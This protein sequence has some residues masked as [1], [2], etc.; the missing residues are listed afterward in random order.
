MIYLIKYA[1]NYFFY[2]FIEV[3]VIYGSKINYYKLVLKNVFFRLFNVSLDIKLNKNFIIQNTFG[4]FSFDKTLGSVLFVTH[5]DI[6]P[7][8]KVEK[9][10]SVAID[11]GANLGF[12]STAMLYQNNFL[13][14][15]YSVEASLDTFNKMK[16]NIALNKLEKKIIPLNIGIGEK[17]SEMDF[18]HNIKNSGLSSFYKDESIEKDSY[19]KIK[20]KIN[21]LAELIKIQKINIKDIGLIKID[22]EGG[23]WNIL[24]NI[25]NFLKKLCSK[26]KVIVELYDKQKNKEDVLSLFKDS[27]FSCDKITDADY[28]FIKK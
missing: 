28:C 15:I 21:S 16:E 13:D 10:F 3:K 20:V 8:L 23:E 4:K 22:V 25:S 19:K 11:I 7:H 17:K 24:K 26:A 1:F 5:K 9:G 12:I 14:S 27:G 6:L 2:H 18:F